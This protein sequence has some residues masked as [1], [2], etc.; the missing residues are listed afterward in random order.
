MGPN[1]EFGYPAGKEVEE[2]GQMQ[3]NRLRSQ[4]A[5]PSAKVARAGFFI[6][7]FFF[8]VF[9]SLLPPAAKALLTRLDRGARERKSSF[10]PDL[11]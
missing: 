1:F 7:Y 9:C 6:F 10:S 11:R 3:P 5:I 4:R 8:N 2:K